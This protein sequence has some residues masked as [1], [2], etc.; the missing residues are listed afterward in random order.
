[1]L[2]VR[3][4]FVIM[5]KSKWK[6]RNAGILLKSETSIFREKEKMAVVYIDRRRYEIPVW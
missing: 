6:F 1:M 2:F 3:G 4:N 5:P